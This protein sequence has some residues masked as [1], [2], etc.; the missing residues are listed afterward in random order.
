MIISYEGH[1]LCLLILPVCPVKWICRNSWR[2]QMVAS[3][4]HSQWSLQDRLFVPVRVGGKWTTY[5]ILKQ[6]LLISPLCPFLLHGCACWSNWHIQARRESRR[7]RSGCCTD[8]SG[9][10]CQNVPNDGPLLAIL[11]LLNIK[12]YFSTG[13]HHLQA[14]RWLTLGAIV[15]T[16]AN[17]I[18]GQETRS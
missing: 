4:R 18:M 2:L 16:D 10:W 14:E 7:N 9:W 8:R 12:K 6:F 3:P 15:T 11:W 17:R 1:P 13:K 5:D